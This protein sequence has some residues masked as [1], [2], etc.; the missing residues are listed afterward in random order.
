MQCC[1]PEIWQEIYYWACTDDG[2]TGRSLSLTCHAVRH[3][4]RPFKL[5]SLCVL[6]V[7]KI[8][9][10]SGFI[11]QIHPSDLN[12]RYLFIAGPDFQ[13]HPSIVQSSQ[14]ALIEEA[15]HTILFAV[16]PTL[17]VLN[18]H[19]P[20]IFRA[21]LFPPI[22]LPYLSDLTLQGPFTSSPASCSDISFPSLTKLHIRHS[23][24][25]PKDF[26]SI[27]ANSAPNL[28]H[29]RVPQRSFTPYELQV[30]LGCMSPA[31]TLLPP[32]LKALEIEADPLPSPEES[33][34][35]SIRAH[36]FLRKFQRISSNDQRVLV[37]KGPDE[38]V[39]CF[40][41]A[42]EWVGTRIQFSVLGDTSTKE[43]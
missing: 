26:L 28:V 18:L 24:S 20:S 5:Q 39:D 15:L 17:R 40:L 23:I 32:S 33:W 7:E 36:Q 3:L 11:L 37:A 1:P 34:K 43:A 31:N 6:G 27:I 12:V 8:L 42:L 41:E 25:R 38:E 4:S 30:A 9:G 16:G 22:P 21:S 35:A 2:S 29:L 14:P 13:A 10:F 19:F